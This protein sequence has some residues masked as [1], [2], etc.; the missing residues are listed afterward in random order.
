VLHEVED[1]ASH[2]DGFLTGIKG[3]EHPARGVGR[4]RGGVVT[5]ASNS[6]RS[7]APPSI[8]SGINVCHRIPMKHEGLLHWFTAAAARLALL[9][10]RRRR[11][12]SVRASLWQWR[13]AIMESER[14]TTS[15]I[16]VRR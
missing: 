5:Q 13:G 12:N 7:V 1:E 15:L 3:G 11:H 10:T 8:G 9:Y 4:F 6:R 14:S 16:V 2:L